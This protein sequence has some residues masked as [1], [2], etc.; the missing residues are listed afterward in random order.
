MTEK[1]ASV[2]K[3]KVVSTAPTAIAARKSITATTMVISKKKEGGGGREREREHQRHVIFDS[4]SPH[5]KKT[6][7]FHLPMMKSVRISQINDDFKFSKENQFFL[8]DAASVPV[9]IE[10]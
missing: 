7:L 9:L 10:I 6:H 5:E 2:I 4:T 3:T 1:L 8:V